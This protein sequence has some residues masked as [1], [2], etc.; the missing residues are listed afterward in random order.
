M[1]PRPTPT[2]PTSRRQDRAEIGAKLT[3]YLNE[4]FACDSQTTSANIPAQVIE[5]IAPQV[6]HTHCRVGYDHGPQVPDPRAPEWSPYMEGHE[7]WWDAIWK[8][9]LARGQQARC[10]C[11]SDWR[12]RS[13]HA[14]CGR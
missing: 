2:T 10:H 5:D 6:Y 9:Q 3:R 12:G 7:R 11:C 1:L 8:A 13:S 14:P 4:F